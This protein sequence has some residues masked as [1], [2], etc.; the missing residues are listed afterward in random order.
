MSI[1]T[2]STLQEDPDRSSQKDQANSTLSTIN[3]ETQ[4]PK[5][6]IPTTNRS[7][8]NR[9]HCDCLQQKHLLQPTKHQSQRHES[10]RKHST[11]HNSKPRKPQ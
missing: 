8:I 4:A 10:K 9:Q 7:K 2:N 6:A 1:W 3:K 5:E 11:L